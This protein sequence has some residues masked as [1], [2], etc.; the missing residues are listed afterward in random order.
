VPGHSCSK[1]NLRM[2]VKISFASR[3][4]AGFSAPRLRRKQAP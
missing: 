2:G 3:V 4:H 1:I